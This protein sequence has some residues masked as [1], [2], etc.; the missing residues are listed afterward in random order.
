[1]QTPQTYVVDVDREVL[2]ALSE[3][4][5][6]HRL[7]GFNATIRMLILR[8][9]VSEYERGIRAGR[10]MRT[11]QYAQGPRWLPATGITRTRG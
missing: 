7:N 10:L 5:H 8:E 3:L 4:T 1:M 9:W 11:A 2:S 6:K